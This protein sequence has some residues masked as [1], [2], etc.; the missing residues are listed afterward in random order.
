MIR[1]DNRV[2][3]IARCGFSLKVIFIFMIRLDNG[4]TEVARGGISL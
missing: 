4:V 1:L 2:L 3:E